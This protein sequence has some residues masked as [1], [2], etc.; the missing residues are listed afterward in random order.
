MSV[1]EAS[2]DLIL[3][4]QVKKGIEKVLCDQHQARTL[5]LGQVN[6][7]SR[8]LEL[9]PDNYPPMSPESFTRN[10]CRQSGPRR[11]SLATP[12]LSGDVLHSPANG[13]A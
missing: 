5:G 10:V 2:V 6:G 8:Y 11:E 1:N 7:A 3:R 4:H 13:Q 12:S 9:A